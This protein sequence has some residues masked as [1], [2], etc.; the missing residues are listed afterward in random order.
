MNGRRVAAVILNWNL[1]METVACAVSLREQNYSPLTMIVVD[2]GSVDDSVDVI[3]RLVPDAKLIALDRNR[4]YAGGMNA[5]I[6][7]ALALGADY[8]MLLNNDVRLRPGALETLVKA[9]E[10]RRTAGALGAVTLS[11]DD[12]PRVLFAG[13]W[14][15][16]GGSW[17]MHSFRAATR[18]RRVDWLEGSVMLLRSS[19]LRAVGLL[20]ESFFLYGEDVELCQ[21]LVSQDFTIVIV[22]EAQAVHR[23]SS[24]FSAA[25]WVR[26]YYLA[27]G[28]VL[29][30]R[31]SDGIVKLC[32]AAQIGI[33]IGAVWS[34]LRS[35]IGEAP[36]Q[37]IGAQLRG[38]WDGLQG[39][40]GLV[41]RY[42][43]VP[44]DRH[45]LGP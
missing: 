8:V 45:T 5:G 44:P 1:P 34:A 31:R 7:E 22:P 16:L 30:A 37:T 20:D 9:A 36:W 19:A 10:A 38:V 4:G 25:P 11:E 3:H 15:L 32:L 14:T 27:R 33:P 12:P 23:T 29:L 43:P 21:R 24:S 40:T 18:I 6:S 17:H 41:D 35:L 26:A 39:R 42:I 13:G 2:N 28:K